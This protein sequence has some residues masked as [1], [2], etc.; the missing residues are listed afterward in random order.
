MSKTLYGSV[1]WPSGVIKF[2]WSGDCTQ[3][4][5]I[6]Q[7]VTGC[8]NFGTGQV[9]VTITGTRCVN[10]NDTYYGC[11]DWTTGK[12]QVIVP[13]ECYGGSVDPCDDC[14]CYQPYA[15]D[16]TFSNISVC[17]DCCEIVPDNPNLPSN[18]FKGTSFSG[19]GTYRCVND[20]AH[21]TSCTWGSDPEEGVVATGISYYHSPDCSEN[22]LNNSYDCI[23]A[24]VTRLMV[25]PESEI[26]KVRVGLLLGTIDPY[27]VC[28]SWVYFFRG[29]AD[30]PD[31]YCVAPISGISN[32]ISCGPDWLCHMAAGGTASIEIGEC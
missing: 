13:D 25:P 6:G 30:C 19:N 27:G 14:D 10:C 31:T 8:I 11:V 24:E 26:C 22:P 7:E 23:K 28:G 4:E 18:S 29:Y 3:P 9:E 5:C 32:D 2:N 20:A 12:F 1:S 16:V 17:S 15:I 21:G